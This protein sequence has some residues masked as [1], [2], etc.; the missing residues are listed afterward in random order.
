[1]FISILEYFIIVTY[2]LLLL[3][4]GKYIYRVQTNED[5]ELGAIIEKK[6]K[7]M[8]FFWFS[9]VLQCPF[10]AVIFLNNY[11]GRSKF[12]RI[13]EDIEKKKIIKKISLL[14]VLIIVLLLIGGFFQD[15]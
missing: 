15:K 2:Q 8:D 1:M 7:Q 6:I 10:Y 13:K 12:M 5:L 4:K 14:D 9:F 3:L 11:N